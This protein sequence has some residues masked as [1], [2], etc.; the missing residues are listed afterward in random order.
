MTIY[1][2][3]NLTDDGQMPAGTVAYSTYYG[4]DDAHALAELQELHGGSASGWAFLRGPDYATVNAVAEALTLVTL[5]NGD[6]PNDDDACA[7]CGTSYAEHR[8][9]QHAFVDPDADTLNGPPLLLR[10]YSFP[11]GFMTG[12]E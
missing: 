1:A 12:G 9:A 7:S 4:D 2:L 6:G 10:S 11:P 5:D 8:Y 3:F